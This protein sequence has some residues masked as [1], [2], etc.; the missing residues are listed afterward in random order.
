DGDEWVITGEKAFITN[1]GTDITSLV[2]VTARTG[3]GEVSAFIVPIGTPGL[4]VGPSYHKL[5]WHAS[6]THPI[7]LD[8]CR[9]PAENLL[10]EQGQ[11]FR[12]CLSI[13][14]EGRV[15]I[16]ALAVGMA[17]GC[18]EHSV[19]YARERHA[20]GR[21][22][23]ANQGLAFQISDMAVA[24]EA[25]RLLTYQAALMVDA[26]K[27][28]KRQAAMA[29]LFSTGAAVD[30]SRIA[31]QVFGGAGYLDEAP[32]ARAYRDAKILEIGE[33]TSEI[34]RLVIA[35]GLGLPL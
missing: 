15:A 8:Q 19:T 23:G 26:G 18:L 14:D 33:G 3:D 20:F 32:V 25:A 12:E 34:Q 6:D 11:G 16:S 7:F 22:I 13:L 30:A 27:P 1:S 4:E 35:R 31:V 5:G 29:K 9:V 21:P 24:V 2:T 10:G 28:V 17:Q